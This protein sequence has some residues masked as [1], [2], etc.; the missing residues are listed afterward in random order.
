[1]E[2]QHSKKRIVFLCTGNSCRS[3]M[4]EGFARHYGK[5]FFDVYSAGISPAGVNPLAV[6]VMKEAEIDISAQTSDPINM[7]VIKGADLLV[8]LCGGARESCPVI[9]GKVEKLHWALDDPAEARGNEEEVLEK[10]REIRDKI[11]QHV[12]ELII[13][14]K[15]M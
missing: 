4:A 3:Q 9:P 6:K 1:M 14:K 11:E 12:K 13:D 7:D 8:T 5:D 15:L 2:Q 10:F